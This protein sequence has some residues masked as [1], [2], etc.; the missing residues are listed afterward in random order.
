MFERVKR[1]KYATVS[2][3]NEAGDAVLH[4][5]GRW[6]RCDNIYNSS[7]IKR[8]YG[9][10]FSR[11]TSNPGIV[12]FPRNMLEAEVELVNEADSDPLNKKQSQKKKKRN[13]WK[14][15]DLKKFMKLQFSVTMKSQKLIIW[16]IDKQWTPTED[17]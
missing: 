8:W 17:S 7:S 15:G 14:K 11:R 10:R 4:E 9:G 1:R 2:K 3:L 16:I 5:W 13:K 12:H 6:E